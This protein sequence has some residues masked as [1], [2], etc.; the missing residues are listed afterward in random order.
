[1]KDKKNPKTKHKPLANS[2]MHLTFC[3]A[4]A[5]FAVEIILLSAFTMK[6]KA[7]GLNVIISILHSC[8][9]AA[10]NKRWGFKY[11]DPVVLKPKTSIHLHVRVHSRR[12]E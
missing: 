7:H 3:G 5:S 12:I 4:I 1:M 8:T 11:Q 6:V 9:I 10:D 2:P